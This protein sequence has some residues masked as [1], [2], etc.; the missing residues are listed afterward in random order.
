LKQRLSQIRSSTIRQRYT[1]AFSNL[2]VINT[3]CYST[4]LRTYGR[5]GRSALPP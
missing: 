1:G 4:H 2:G 5:Y 3:A